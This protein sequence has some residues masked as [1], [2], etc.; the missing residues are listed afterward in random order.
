[1]IHYASHGKGE[2]SVG[3]ELH[4]CMELRLQTTTRRICSRLRTRRS[5]CIILLLAICLTVYQLLSSSQ[6]INSEKARNSRISNSSSITAV[7]R[8]TTTTEPPIVNPY[9]YNYTILPKPCRDEDL[10][11][12]IHSA[13]QVNL[14]NNKINY[15]E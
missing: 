6:D 8:P 15:I 13:V 1:M 14:S 5:G 2:D 10:L 11:I 7:I 3:T 12:V 4:S 9:P